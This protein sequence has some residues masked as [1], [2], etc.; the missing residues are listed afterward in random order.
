MY[1]FEPRFVEAILR[2]VFSALVRRS[3][4]RREPSKHG[5]K[6]LLSS[7]KIII[8]SAN[9]RWEDERQRRYL[10]RMQCTNWLFSFRNTLRVGG[11]F[12]QLNFLLDLKFRDLCVLLFF[13]ASGNVSFGC[14]RRHLCL[15]S[16]V[17][18]NFLSRTDNENRSI[19][20]CR[21]PLCSY[22]V[23]KVA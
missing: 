3:R 15:V 21:M 11:C 12:G 18:T 5:H 22:T 17:Y 7:E 13:Q 23:S 14:W 9:H 19:F 2:F 10:Q 1:C 8:T 4:A 20:W 6:F 16:D